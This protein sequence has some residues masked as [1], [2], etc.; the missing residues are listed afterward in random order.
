VQTIQEARASDVRDM[1]NHSKQSYNYSNLDLKAYLPVNESQWRA[2]Y[3]GVLV[4]P[5][6]VE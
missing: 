4:K 5:K 2:R 3:G 1:Q 6:P